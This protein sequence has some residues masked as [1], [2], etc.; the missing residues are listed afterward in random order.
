MIILDT[1][2]LSALMRPLPEP[3]V[4]AWLDRQPRSSVWVNSITVLEVQHGI[5]LLPAGK[6]CTGLFEMFD[7]L[8]LGGLDRR[9][10]GFDS[11]AAHEAANLMTA[12]RKTGRD[13][14]LKDAMIAGI[15]IARH[16]TLAT[17]NTRHF[18][19]LPGKVV[20]PWLDLR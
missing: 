7:R 8:V 18:D 5:Q 6:R 15:V 20:N 16:A 11:A 2:V 12:R 19:D 9:I 17:R 14:E 4:A 1:N 13:Y 3:I 10:A